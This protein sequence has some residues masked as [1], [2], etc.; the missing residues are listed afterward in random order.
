MMN[1]LWNSWLFGRFVMLIHWDFSNKNMQHWC[2]SKVMF[3]IVIPSSLHA[4]RK[5]LVFMTIALHRKH[6]NLCFMWNMM[7][8]S[9]YHLNLLMLETP[10]WPIAGWN[11]P[12]FNMNYIDSIRA[13][14]PLLLLMVPQ[15]PANQ[16]IWYKSDYLQGFIQSFG[17]D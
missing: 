14:F 6:K 3:G 9:K 15:N 16:L 1:L 10:L 11:I 2:E 12:I 4:W 17:D 5:N 13:H 8:F 7:P